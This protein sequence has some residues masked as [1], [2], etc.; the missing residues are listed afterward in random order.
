LNLPGMRQVLLLA[1]LGA[2]LLAGNGC[3]TTGERDVSTIPWNRPQPWEG[4]GGFGGFRPQ[5][6]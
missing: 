3:A 5:N 6:Y 1:C 2:W 4:A